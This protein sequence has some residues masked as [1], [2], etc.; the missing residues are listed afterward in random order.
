MS[1]TEIYKFRKDGNVEEFA[2]VKNAWRGAMA[3]WNT[4]DEKYLPKYIPD[5]AKL[6]G[7]ENKVYHRSSDFTGNALKEVWGLSLKENVSKI[8]KIVLRSTFDNVIVY[9]DNIPELIEAFRKFEGDTSLKEQADLIELELSKD[10][11]LI[12]ICWN[13]TSVNYGVWT[14]EELDEDENYLPYNLNKGDKH[15]SLFA[16]AF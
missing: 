15:W 9:R 7:E 2:E 12:A 11:E 3:V 14:S 13:Q 16:D 10:D 6:M 1:Y 8:D 4:L 5:W